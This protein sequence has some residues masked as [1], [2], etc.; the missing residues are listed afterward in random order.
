MNPNRCVF[1]KA[2]LNLLALW[3]ASLS[4]IASAAE[5]SQSV[6]KPATKGYNVLF[7]A[8]DD[9]NDWVGCLGGNSQAITPN[10]DRFAKQKAMV[11]NKAYCAST[12]AYGNNQNFKNAPIAKDVITLPEY[13]DKNGCFTISSGKIFDKHTTPTGVDKVK[14]AS[15]ELAKRG[16]NNQGML[17]GNHGWHLREKLKY[18]KFD[19]WEKSDRGP[20][21][22]RVPGMTPP[23][24]KC[25]GIV[26]LLDI[27][28]TLLEHKNLAANSEFKEIIV[29]FKTHLPTHDE[30]DSPRNLTADGNPKSVA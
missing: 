10:M 18:G 17:W 19:L 2:A 28:P 8:V 5:S 16:G 14:R 30:P 27:Y 7:I 24:V 23:D 29:R 26:N 21:I 4:T 22:V 25:Q 9:M 20:L 6:E 15:H 11:M 1:P 3:V 13:F 12:G